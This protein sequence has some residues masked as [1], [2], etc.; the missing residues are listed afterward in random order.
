MKN[1][2]NVLL[3]YQIYT[4]LLYE[5]QFSVMLQV[6]CCRLTFQGIYVILSFEDIEIPGSKVKDRQEWKLYLSC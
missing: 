6:F 1:L 3:L 5:E 2:G 4:S